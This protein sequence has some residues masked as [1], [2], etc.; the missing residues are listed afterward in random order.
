M[1]II[2]RLRER[3]NGNGGLDKIDDIE[4]EIKRRNRK[5]ERELR[6]AE[7]KANRRERWE[8]LSGLLGNIV[9]SALGTKKIGLVAA[10]A[11]G[12]ITLAGI[13]KWMM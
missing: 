13:L 1:K 7:K 4:R 3:K 11:I 5:A 6:R 9:G 12:A 2:D 10:L 8:F